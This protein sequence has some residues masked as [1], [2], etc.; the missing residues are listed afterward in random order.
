M[1]KDEGIPGFQKQVLVDPERLR[2]LE[3]VY[4]ERLTENSQLKKAAHLVAKQAAILMSNDIPLGMKKALV[5]PLA[6]EKRQW[7]KAT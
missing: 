4:R 2:Q 5:K 7:T 1:S 6:R 3:E